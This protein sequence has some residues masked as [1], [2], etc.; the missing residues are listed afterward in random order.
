MFDKI[1]FQ[2]LNQKLK[3]KEEKIKWKKENQLST[4]KN[5]IENPKEFIE[6]KLLKIQEENEIIASPKINFASPAKAQ[7]V[8]KSLILNS[9]SQFSSINSNN[10]MGI[11]PKEQKFNANMNAENFMKN[12]PELQKID[13]DGSLMKN[14][15]SILKIINSPNYD[16]LI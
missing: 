14:I 10:K 2:K 4:L 16:E 15:D 8:D 6:P 11:L 1:K 5:L 9:T 12:H 13:S 7:P 3:K